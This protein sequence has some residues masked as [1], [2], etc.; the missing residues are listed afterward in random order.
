MKNKYRNLR[1][2]SRRGEPRR[3]F[4]CRQR[5]RTIKPMVKA[6]RRN[7]RSEAGTIWSLKATN[8]RCLFVAFSDGM[9]ALTHLAMLARLLCWSPLAT[10]DFNTVF[11]FQRTST[12]GTRVRCPRR[13]VTP[14]FRC[15]SRDTIKNT[16]PPWVKTHVYIQPS[17]CDE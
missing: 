9:V 6:L 2:V 11:I 10:K 12:H 3:E 15:R 13:V 17:C 7:H 5:R 4:F 16:V 14:E 8:T 1:R